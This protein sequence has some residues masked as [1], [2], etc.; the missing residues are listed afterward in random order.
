MVKPGR[1]IAKT[2]R[3]EGNLVRRIAPPGYKD[4]PEA[5][6]VAEEKKDR[7]GKKKR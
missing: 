7:A 1:T 4:E 2:Y 6:P 5:H 3:L